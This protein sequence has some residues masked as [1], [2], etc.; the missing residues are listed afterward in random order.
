MNKIKIFYQPY[1]LKQEYFENSEYLNYLQFIQMKEWLHFYQEN[2]DLLTKCLFNKYLIKNLEKEINKTYQKQWI[3][4]K[5]EKPISRRLKRKYKTLKALRN[6]FELCHANLGCFIKD[7][8]DK[9]NFDFT[10]LL[11]KYSFK[12]VNQK[13]TNQDLEHFRNFIYNNKLYVEI[14]FNIQKLMSFFAK[15]PVKESNFKLEIDN[16]YSHFGDCVDMPCI[17][18][19]CEIE[20]FLG[21]STLTS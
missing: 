13:L 16:W 4:N 9:Q 7:V 21:I 20:Y 19:Q 1:S 8:I 14:E 12:D 6:K 17:C 18:Q 2:Q 11:T 5:K 3:L 10:Q 15:T